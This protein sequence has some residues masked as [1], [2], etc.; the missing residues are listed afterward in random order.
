MKKIYTDEFKAKVALELIKGNKTLAQLSSE[1]GVHTTQLI[2][3]KSIAIKNLPKV[4]SSETKP[5]EKKLST[6][7]TEKDALYS[8]IGRLTTQLN[9]LKKKSGIDYE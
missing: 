5:L 6:I 2:Q 4:F 7:E 1:F 9:W 3:W 8:Q